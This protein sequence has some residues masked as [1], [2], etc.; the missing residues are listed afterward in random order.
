MRSPIRLVAP[1]LIPLL[2]VWLV[3]AAGLASPPALA[4]TDDAQEQAGQSA[5]SP[6]TETGQPADE[7]SAK[8]RKQQAKDKRIEEY[9][10]K[11]DERRDEKQAKESTRRARGEA[12]HSEAAARELE[13]QQLAAQAD[14]EKRAR[15][16]A[17]PPP[18]DAAATDEEVA[19]R[20]ARRRG[21]GSSELPR[22]LARAQANIRSTELALDPTVDE[23]L[24]L[25]DQQG[26]S[27]HELAAFANFIAENGMIRDALEYYRVALL[28]ADDDPVLWINAGTLHLQTK[29]FSAASG[30]FSR[31]LALDPNNAM[32][33]YNMGATHDLT[34][35]YEDAIESY[36]TALFLDP[37][38]GDPVY[39]PRAANN[40]LLLAVKLLLYQEQTG[41]SA[42]PL[43]DVSTGRLPDAPSDDDQ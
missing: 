12:K 4:Q 24:T 42:V 11:R 18:D 16:A 43:L 34:N 30:H 26:A 40:D 25:I 33:H 39:N 3:V 17:L 27:P 31:A 38:L 15:Q 1:S 29:N 36:K 8:E 22:G 21:A 7:L 41:S 19:M 37:S 28:L 9:L 14:A 20:R 13:Q 10:R 32:A 23:Y 35:R 6:E 5:A 2:A